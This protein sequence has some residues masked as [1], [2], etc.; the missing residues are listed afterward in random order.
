MKRSLRCL[1]AVA[2]LFFSTLAGA[3][4]LPNYNAI[5]AAKPAKSALSQV[6]SPAAFVASTDD[7]RGVPTFLWAAR[8]ASVGA[9]AGL[10]HVP[11]LT[12][13]SAARLHLERHASRYGLAREALATARVSQIHDL[14]RGGIIVVLRQAPGGIELFHNDVKVL[15][16]R[17]LELVAIGGNLHAGAV[18]H[19]KTHGFLAAETSALAAA[20]KDLHGVGV[21]PSAFLDTKQTKGDYHY[22]DLGASPALKGTDLHFVDPAR[23]KRVY[24]PLPDRL[25]PAYFLELHTQ[26]LGDVESSAYAYVI[27]ADDGRLLYRENLTHGEIFNYRVYADATG[28]HRP[29]DG[30]IAD[31]CPHPTG[32]PDGSKP[33]FATPNLI[34]IDGFNKF[35]DPWLPAGA[36]TSTG[37]NVDAYTDDGKPNGFSTND[38]RATTTSANTF[39][40]SYDTSAGPQ[41]SA[42]QK[43]ASIIDLFYVTN[44]LHDWWYDSG[45]DEAAGNAQKSNLGRGGIGGDVLLAEA[46]DGA[47]QQRNN[48]NISVFGDGGSPR[49]QMFVWDGISATTLGVQPL[50]QTLPNGVAQFGP[51]SFDLSGEVVLANDG[52][53]PVTDV[54]QAITNNVAGKIVLV[55]RGTCTFKSKAVRVQQAGAAG[56]I[57]INNT[58]GEA[59][60]YMPN[61][62]GGGPVTIPS[63]S[64]TLADGNALKAALMN[65]PVN[66]TMS[67]SLSVDRD[68]TLDNSVIAH[69]WG[70]YIHLRQVACGSAA[71]SAESEGWGDFFA[72]HQAVREG[73][74]L[75]AV[76]PMA[77]YATAAFPDDPNYFGIRRYPY[78]VDFSKNALTFK[79]ITDGQDLPANVP[80]AQYTAQ[81]NNAEAHAAG[82]VWAAM[83]FEA[84]VALLKKSQGPSAPYTFDEARRR[85]GDYVE[86]GLKLAPVDPTFTEQRDAILA[87]AAAADIDDLQVLAQ[88]FARRGAGTCA[89]S[90]PRDSQDFSGV[91]ESFTV[92]PNL[93]IV[94]VTVDDSVTSCDGDGK[95]D[96]EETGKVTVTVQNTGTAPIDSAVASVVST[97]EGVT[98]PSGNNITFGAL[99]PFG[100][101]TAS[102]DVALAPT[103]LEMQ[104]IDLKVALEGVSS[105]NGDATLTTAPLGNYD[106]MPMAS[107]LDTVETDDTTWKPQGQEGASIWTRIETSPGNRVWAGS[108]H[109]SPSD[110]YL[111]SP[112]LVVSATDKL[113]LSFDHRYSFEQS[114]DIGW[115]GSVIEIS[116]G[117]G[118]EDITTYGDPGYTG[119]IGDPQGQAQNPLIDRPGYIG[120]SASWP[121]LEKQTI[122]LGNTL[123]GKTIRIRFRIGTDDAAGDNGWEIDNIQLDGITNK[124]FSSLV[125]DK[126][127]CGAGPVANAG[128]DQLATGGALVTL[129]GSQSAD[130]GGKPLTYMWKQLTGTAVPLTDASSAKPTFTAPSVQTKATLTFELTVKSDKG[131]SSDTV[132]VVVSPADGGT[133]KVEA[134]GGCGCET[135]GNPSG[136]GA[137]ASLLALAGLFI[138]RRR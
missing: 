70:H 108:N 119:T 53:A 21:D 44:W 36:T 23:I 62:Q 128:P 5:Y 48:S 83:L 34:A 39:D 46:Q 60:P 9:A 89:V 61:A 68:G 138:R 56:M 134:F 32:T 112:Q 97:A 69:E 63:M 125:D 71:C 1:L 122:D 103:L 132:A 120:Q 28:D 102:I 130:P 41:S 86:G 31:F 16:D 42:D 26:R 74:D 115:D 6:R 105:C 79:H 35:K 55:D 15:L 96:A 87:A 133:D 13:E 3:K 29:M 7:R 107:T 73:D 33:A 82:E 104:N 37:N 118:W 131:A 52:N 109:P 98:F 92:Q 78:S 27:A 90:P 81:V 126:G 117:N 136:A 22:Y 124:P 57:L 8:S 4:D 64:I 24:F 88:A 18:A 91:V 110:T 66:V 114:N 10:T 80:V 51:Q 25:V 84:Y 106:V 135:K 11:N 30:P 45:F 75:D 65:G 116:A 127:T 38:I 121:A 19:P 113:V 67:R 17:K 2:P 50:N 94:S 43:M 111:V 49:M 101:A 14:G 58:P 40:R 99:P 72:L 59:P 12:P 95:L 100:T 85:M 47:P 93:A 129:D 54:C 137:A 77:Q 76:Y 20:F 123:A